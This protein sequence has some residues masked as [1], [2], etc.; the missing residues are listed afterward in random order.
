MILALLL[1]ASPPPLLD[2]GIEAEYFVSTANLHAVTTDAGF[3]YGAF[4]CPGVENG[5][6]CLSNPSGI[7]EI[8]GAMP[9]AGTTSMLVCDVELYAIRRRTAGCVLGVGNGPSSDKVFT[10]D[11]A[12]DVTIA[13]S[14][15]RLQ[16]LNA[17][18]RAEGNWPSS[19]GLRGNG[20]GVGYPDVFITGSHTR[21]PGEHLFDAFNFGVGNR[22]FIDW[23]G[24]F[25]SAARAPISSVDHVAAFMAGGTA[26]ALWNAGVANMAA[27]GCCDSPSE[28][29]Q[30]FVHDIGDGGSGWAYCSNHGWVLP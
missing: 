22:A 7:V 10:I 2:G 17:Q 21:G 26:P 18:I 5:A 19:L 29:A 6:P 24:A 16:G 1:A 23:D 25:Y 27:L 8:H 9:D 30:Q 4:M 3:S 13:G 12:S 15:L 11:Y 20:S 14:S 28:S